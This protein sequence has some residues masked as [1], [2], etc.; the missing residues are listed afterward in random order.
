VT[1]CPPAHEQPIGAGA[2][3]CPPAPTPIGVG[4][5]GGC[6]GRLGDPNADTRVRESAAKRLEIPIEDVGPAELRVYFE[7]LA[8]DFEREERNAVWSRLARRAAAEITA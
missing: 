1:T 3:T 8:D 4:G 2:P 6:P 7:I 5:L